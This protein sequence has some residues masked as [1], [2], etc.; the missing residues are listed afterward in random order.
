MTESGDCLSC[1]DSFDGWEC[2]ACNEKI[3]TH[4]EGCH[5]EKKHGKITNQNIHICGGGSGSLNSI[6]KDHDAYN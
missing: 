1:G 3:T 4:C 5:N 6:D 2:E